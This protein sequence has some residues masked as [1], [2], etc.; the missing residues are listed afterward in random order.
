MLDSGY[1]QAS[2]R[3]DTGIASGTQNLTDDLIGQQLV[4]SRDA[5]D[6]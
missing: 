3:E 4:D 2:D 1:V 6:D 5:N